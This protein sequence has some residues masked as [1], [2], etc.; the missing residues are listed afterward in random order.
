MERDWI[1]KLISLAGAPILFV[2]KPDKNLRLCVDYRAFNKFI[3]RNR[4][5]LPLIDETINRLAGIKVYTKL[6]LRDA[7]H[8][9]RIKP[10][11]KWKIA[12]RTRYGHYEYIIIPF[13]LTNAPATFQAY[14]NETLNNYLDT[15]CV[16]YIDDICIYNDSLE[17]HEE[18]VRKVL[19][20]LRKYGLYA[21]L[22]KC[23]FHKIEIQ[24]LGFSMGIAGVSMNQAKVKIILK[25]PIPQNFRDIQI[26]MGFANFYRR[27][28][29][30]FSKIT[31]PITDLLKGMVK[32]RKVKPFD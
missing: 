5:P 27:F 10:G 18:H 13:N 32:G 16:A 11:D 20:R 7:Y 15:F 8:R 23:E 26:F 9:I 1:K 30:N 14:I 4:H 17:K 21:K 28:I 2:K 31:K 19:D 29:K 12:F 6:D 22:S 25:W 3:I 24:F